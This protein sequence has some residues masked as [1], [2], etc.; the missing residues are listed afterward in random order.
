MLSATW[1]QFD[2]KRGV[3]TKPS[4]HTKQKTIEHVPLSRAALDVLH[5]VKIQ[6]GPHLFP[7]RFQGARV[8]LR[9]PWIQVLKA[10]GFVTAEPY[11][12]KRGRILT[13]YKPTVRIHDLSAYLRE[14]SGEPW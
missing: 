13:R 11:H 14:S 3:W 1:E 8:T 6:T 12:G 10:A 2:L 4:A 5:R 9:R 7:G